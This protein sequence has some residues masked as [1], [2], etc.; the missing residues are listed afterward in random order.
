MWRVEAQAPGSAV[1]PGLS[2]KHLSPAGLGPPAGAPFVLTVEARV[3]RPCSELAS[4]C[5][6]STRPLWHG[7]QQWQLAEHLLTRYGLGG[8]GGCKGYSLD[9]CG[10]RQL[11]E[12]TASI[13]TRSGGAG[14]ASPYV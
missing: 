11:V 13:A 8:E 12:R 10:D 3:A 6:L 7:A 5:K 1:G 4:H 14:P 2:S 9:A